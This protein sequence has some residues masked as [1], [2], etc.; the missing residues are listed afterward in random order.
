[1]KK[2]TRDRKGRLS[3]FAIPDCKLFS[4]ISYF[5]IPLLQTAAYYFNLTVTRNNL[6]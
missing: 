2:N 1:M 4:T 3:F 5:C 6:R